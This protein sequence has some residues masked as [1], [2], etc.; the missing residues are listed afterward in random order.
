M[1]RN[2]CWNVTGWNGTLHVRSFKTCIMQWLWLHQCELSVHRPDKEDVT[3]RQTFNHLRNRSV[4][5]VHTAR[6]TPGR[7]NVRISD[8]TVR[9]RLHQCGLRAR[10]PLKGSTL[11]QR[12]RAAPLQCPSSSHKCLMSFKSGDNAGH[13]RVRIWLSFRKSI[14]SRATWERAL[15]CWKTWLKRCLRFLFCGKWQI[16]MKNEKCYS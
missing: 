16:L 3:F 11:K 7:T 2:R 4:T 10:R 9:N 15:S 14:D 8:Q 1:K 12:H 5:T 6:L 13:G